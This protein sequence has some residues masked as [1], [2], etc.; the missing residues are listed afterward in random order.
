[1]LYKY[2]ILSAFTLSAL[3]TKK[4]ETKG[5]ALNDEEEIQNNRAWE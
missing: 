5:T 4:N 2:E 1:M 3:Y